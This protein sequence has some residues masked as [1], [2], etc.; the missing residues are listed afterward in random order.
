MLRKK[1]RVGKSRYSCATSYSCPQTTTSKQMSRGMTCN[2]STPKSNN[3]LFFAIAPYAKFSILKF[4]SFLE[5]SIEM[6]GAIFAWLTIPLARL[7][8]SAGLLLPSCCC[9]GTSQHSTRGL[10]DEQPTRNAPPL[11]AILTVLVG[12][13]VYGQHACF[14]TELL[15]SQSESRRFES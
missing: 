12:P 2:E 6:F 3:D 8:L 11:K 13:V 9:P 15:R 5:S 1:W 7:Q 10:H 4:A 14:H